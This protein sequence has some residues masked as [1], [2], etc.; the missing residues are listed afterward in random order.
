MVPEAELLKIMDEV[1]TQLDIGN[2]VIKVMLNF[3]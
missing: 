3:Y 1:F 2:Y